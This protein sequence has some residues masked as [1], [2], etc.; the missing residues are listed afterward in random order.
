MAT[1]KEGRREQKPRSD[2]QRDDVRE[3][4]QNGQELPNGVTLRFY[5]RGNAETI[6]EGE[7]EGDDGNTGSTRSPSRAG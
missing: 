5:D 2:H 1:K 7:A 4:L 6:A 3:A